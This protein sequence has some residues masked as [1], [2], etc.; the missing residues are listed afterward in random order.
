MSELTAARPVLW[1]WAHEAL[2]DDEC[3]RIQGECD[4]YRAD[5]GTDC[6]CAIV[7]AILVFCEVLACK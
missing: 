1:W 4:R 5:S 6:I 7:V 2:G 3:D